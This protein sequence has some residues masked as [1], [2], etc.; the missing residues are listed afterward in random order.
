MNIWIPRHAMRWFSSFNFWMC[1]CLGLWLLG[2][3]SFEFWLVD[4]AAHFQV[5]YAIAL[6]ILILVAVRQRL[7][8]RFFFLCFPLLFCLNTLLPYFPAQ[9]GKTEVTNQMPPRLRI[10]HANV[11]LKNRNPLPVLKLIQETEPEIVSL[12]EV[13]PAWL[14]RLAPVLKRYPYQVT[15]VKP[16]CI[17]G[18][19][20]FSKSPLENPEIHYYGGIG[21]PTLLA[22][23]QWQGRRI[24]LVAMHP[25]SPG[26]WKRYL[27]RNMQL[28]AFAKARK[29]LGPNLIVMGDLNNTPFS[30]SF[31]TLL[32]ETGLHNSR[33]G[34][35]LY[36]TWPAALPML[37]I[38]IDH[39]L[40]SDS[41]R[42][43]AMRVGPYIGSDHL[44]LI[45]EVEW[46]SAMPKN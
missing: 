16:G 13:D 18:V 25:H 32:K 46:Q 36:P 15:A 45:A 41:L 31:K 5:Q 40:L 10:L 35:G 30:P 43:H 28:F 38:P 4:L 11:L 44:P 42:I 26:S 39:I 6:L 22:D 7:W 2:N 34:Q 12:Q 27:W 24:T 17:Y 37:W 9:E 23:L 19:A 29:T 33:Q 14:E 21:R 20:L 1:L 3:L 8:E